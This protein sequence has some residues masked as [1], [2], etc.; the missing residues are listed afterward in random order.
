MGLLGRR[1]ST[2]LCCKPLDRRKR[3]P[4]QVRSTRRKYYITNSSSQRHYSPASLDRHTTTCFPAQRNST[5]IHTRHLVLPSVS[6]S[7]SPPRER[8][9]NK[10]D[11]ITISHVNKRGQSF[12]ATLRTHPSYCRLEFIVP[13]VLSLT[14]SQQPLETI[15]ESPTPSKQQ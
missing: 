5:T 7:L 12:S 6:S 3:Y 4:G 11:V 9:R 8:F 13:I 15:L 2:S 10:T 1:A 14:H